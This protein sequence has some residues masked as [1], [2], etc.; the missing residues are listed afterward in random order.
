VPLDLA[1]AR[2]TGLSAGALRGG[3]RSWRDRLLA[4]PRFQRWAAA[5]PLTRPI[6]RNRARALFD[7][8]AGFVYSQVLLACLQLRLFD[9][10]FE[11]PQSADALAARL[12]IAPAAMQRLLSAAASLRLVERRG[13]VL[14]GLGPL[15]AAVVGNPGIAA[16]IEHNALLYADLQ[17]PVTLL[18][19]GTRETAIGRFWPYAAAADG[20]AEGDVPADAAASYSRLMGV[21]QAM[22]AKDVIAAYPFSRHRRLL[23]VGGGDGTFLATVF[24]C[25]PSLDLMLFDLPPVAER[26]ARRFADPRYGGRARA[27]GGSFLRDPLPGGADVVSL[28]RVLHD[29]DDEP[30]MALLRAA[31][32]ALPADGVLLIAE[33]MVHESRPDPVGDAY[34]G[35]YLLAMGSGRARTAPEIAR[36]M[37][38]A[39][40]AE[41]RERPT[42]QP[43]LTRVLTGK[44]D[45]I[46]RQSVPLA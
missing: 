3:W 23:D 2:R 20:R 7:L 41:I 38:K 14:W 26:A 43:M 15:G 31:R 5:F 34:F 4:S 9:V 13:P 45:R 8:C 6:A 37:A 32:A 24:E 42:C 33:P 16:M 30:A 1:D 39:G 18:R 10:L 22:I 40:F 44:P 17:D 36:M 12:S 35:L 25:V 11:G 19:G 27:I 29:H 21:S 46:T 28:V